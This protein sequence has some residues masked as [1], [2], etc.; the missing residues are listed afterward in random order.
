M[1]R[2]VALFSIGALAQAAGVSPHLIRSWE[3]RHS[4]LSPGRSGGGQRL[5]GP[6]DV[7]RLKLLSR[8]VAAGHAI[9]AV[10]SLDNA[11]LEALVGPIDAQ[12]DS[13]LSGAAERAQQI[14]LDAVVRLDT[15]AISRALARAALAFSPLELI[16]DVVW[17][18]LFEIGKRWQEGSLSSAQEHAASAVIRSQLVGLIHTLPQSP[19]GGLAVV[20]TTLEGEPH[21]IGALFAAVV[22][23]S[24]G[25][26]VIYLGASVPCADVIEAV[27]RASASVVLVS[28]I[29][30]AGPQA[31]RQLRSLVAALPRRVLVFV[32]GQGLDALDLPPGVE[33]CR[34]V[35][36]DSKLRSMQ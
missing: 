10:A 22:A 9:G 18:V 30:L 15:E 16:Q 2:P 34:L 21:D 32:G 13:H 12:N 1:P 4:A 5:Y 3:R 7:A 35:D 8:A 29:T 28:F 31:T 27:Q 11:S 17:P 19:H 20:C 33:V 6:D 23:A 14:I 26:R 36:L 24:H 25:H